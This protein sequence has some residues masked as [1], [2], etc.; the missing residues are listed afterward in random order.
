MDATK[1]AAL[2]AGV[3]AVLATMACGGSDDGEKASAVQKQEALVKCE[4]INEC[5]GTSE[6]KSSDGK[7]GC[8]G[9][10]ECKG[11]GWISVPSEECAAKN[12]KVIG[13]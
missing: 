7:S 10:N 5:K 13:G 6:C 11:Q 2:A 8:Q 9:L 4:G 12:G 1:A 3:A